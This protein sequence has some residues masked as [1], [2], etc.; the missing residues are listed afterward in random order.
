MKPSFTLSYGLGYQLELPPYELDGKQVMLVDQNGK[1][2]VTKDYL[3]KR[4]AAALAGNT[5]S[6]D[7]NPILGFAT[8]KNV[9]GGRKYPYDTFYG[10][11]SPRIAAAWNPR[12]DGGILGSI[13]GENKSV[14]R[15]GWGRM[16]GRAN[17]VLNILTPLLAPGLLQ[18]V[19][20]QGLVFTPVNIRHCT[21]AQD[22]N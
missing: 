17:G 5:T 2:V 8:V 16:Y 3:A 15:G 4:K 19:S 13:F 6:P 9:T 20:C 18:A 12:F 1:P 7:Y 21:G 11:L 22:G 10:G 14:I